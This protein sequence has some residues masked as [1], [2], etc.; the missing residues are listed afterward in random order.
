MAIGANQGLFYILILSLYDNS[1]KMMRP[2]ILTFLLSFFLIQAADSQ[3]L[4][5]YVRGAEDALAKKDYFSAYNFMR[6]A[7]EIEPN[8]VEYTYKL[9]EAARLYSAFTR[10]E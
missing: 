1:S 9:A 2:L 8:N 7:H 4:N 10:A 5:A 6:T 3:T